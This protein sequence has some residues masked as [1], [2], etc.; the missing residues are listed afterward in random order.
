MPHKY[1]LGFWEVERDQV[2]WLLHFKGE[3]AM[4]MLGSGTIIQINNVHCY[5]ALDELSDFILPITVEGYV[6]HYRLI[7][8]DTVEGRLLLTVRFCL[9]EPNEFQNFL[10]GLDM[11][12]YAYEVCAYCDL[13]SGIWCAE[14]MYS[15]IIIFHLS[16]LINHLMQDGGIQLLVN[17]CM[18][19]MVMV[20][21]WERGMKKKKK[22]I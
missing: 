12:E 14:G 9:L 21:P 5:R 10:M 19:M 1:S 11:W 3:I 17:K 15:F 13:N 20:S 7:E 18:K 16:N 8:W 4:Y 2:E 6:E 22:I